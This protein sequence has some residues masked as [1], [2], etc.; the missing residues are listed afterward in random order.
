MINNLYMQNYSLVASEILKLL[1][2]LAQQKPLPFGLDMPLLQKEVHACLLQSDEPRIIRQKRIKKE[3]EI[4]AVISKMARIY[5]A[6]YDTDTVP[7]WLKT[8]QIYKEEEL[9]AFFTN[10]P[11]HLSDCSLLMQEKHIIWQDVQKLFTE[12][13]ILKKRESLH[14]ESQTKVK[15]L[16]KMKKILQELCEFGERFPSNFS[17]QP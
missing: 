11:K 13:K 14:A 5:K 3:K 1:E 8:S 17:I 7:N 15:K 10:I 16:R 4:W 2:Q 9:F 12:W 6:V